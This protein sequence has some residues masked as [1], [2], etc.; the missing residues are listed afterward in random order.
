L[1]ICIQLILSGIAIPV[2]APVEYGKN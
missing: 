1:L 2:P